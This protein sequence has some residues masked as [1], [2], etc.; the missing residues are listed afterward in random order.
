MNYFKSLL[1]A[2]LVMSFYSSCGP[3]APAVK[4]IVTV[5]TTDSALL[6]KTGEVLQARISSIKKIK[7]LPGWKLELLMEQPKGRLDLSRLSEEL[8]QMGKLDFLEACTNIELDHLLQGLPQQDMDF[9]RSVVKNGNAGSFQLI[10]RPA[11][12]SAVMRILHKIK[13]ES[14]LFQW[15]FL[16]GNDISQNWRQKEKPSTVC[17]YAVKLPDWADAFKASY[18]NKATYNLGENGEPEVSISFSF[19]GEEWFKNITERVSH[20]GVGTGFLAIALDNFVL[21]CPS[22]REKI[23]G[24]ARISGGFEDVYEAKQVADIINSK[25]LPAK[26]L[27]EK[28]E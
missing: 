27:V 20:R 9:M 5:D 3:A 19:R 22:V 14:L 21:T 11:D 24:N 12:T 23:E 25:P 28:I 18:V 7:P 26:I 8:Q 4:M 10:V 16:Y 17:I 15:T 13:P 6:R 2:G 1:L